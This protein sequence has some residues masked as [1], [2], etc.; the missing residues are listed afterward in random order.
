MLK[1]VFS[2]GGSAVL[3]RPQEA[4]EEI[5]LQLMRSQIDAIN[6]VQ[7]VIR[8]TLD[9]IIL[10]ANENFLKTMGYTLPEIKGKHHRIFV[11]PKYASSAAYD[12][13]WR[14]LRQ[15]NFEQRQ[16]KRFRKD[17]QV[18]W[19]QA[20]Y[21]PVFDKDGRPVE[22][23]KFATD[24]T[25]SK[26]LSLDSCGK[27]EAVQRTQAFIE[28]SL[29]GEVLAANSIFLDLLGYSFNEVKGRHHSM[30][31]EQGEDKTEA[32]RKMWQDLRAGIPYIRV[33]KRIGKNGRVVWIQANYNPILD[34]EGKPI[35]V[36]KFASDLTPVVHQ[37]ELSSR[38]AQ[39]VAA[40]TEEMSA[41]IE[42]IS[43]NMEMSRQATEKITLTAHDS[44]SE[45]NNLLESMKSMEKIVGLIREIA[46]RVNMLS[47]NATIEAARAGEAGKGFA[48]VAGEV[49]SLSD[50][51]AKATNEIGQEIASVQKISG[52]V[53]ES[54]H[55]TLEGITMVGQYVN[56]V[57]SALTE[58][59]ATTREISEHT[60]SLVSAVTEIME[61]TRKGQVA[62]DNSLRMCASTIE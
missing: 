30:F 28:F 55:Q 42:E 11:D 3:D 36:V 49:K 25:E 41:S 51:T 13:F 33:C 1:N 54:I 8:F 15:G 29:E 21:N 6:R 50:Q 60:A 38:T 34:L 59:S 31:V 44:G 56:S 2:R 32:Y 39:S 57:A 26:L 43:R 58:Q 14:M 19:L 27:I 45:A 46:G 53:A 37:T 7:A 12:E 9:G 10:D 4:C 61:Q 24:V 18:V 16:Y 47:L 20:S 62:T 48:V 35:K 22:V 5:D 40:A 23:I 52:K 17:G